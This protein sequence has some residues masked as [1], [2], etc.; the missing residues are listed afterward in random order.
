MPQKVAKIDRV[1]SI[2]SVGTVI[3]LP[4]EDE[5]L[6]AP[7]TAIRN[8]ERIQIRT[9]EGHCISTFIRSIELIR[10]NP[11]EGSVCFSL[12]HPIAV[13][14]IPD[15]SELWLERDGDGVSS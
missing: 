4:R 9:P 3:A 10:R 6:M 1:F 8:S 2:K 14:D 5:W 12:P 11:E 15:G 13:E 7:A